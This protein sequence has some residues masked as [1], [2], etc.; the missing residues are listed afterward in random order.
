MIIG[1]EAVVLGPCGVS[2]FAA[3]HKHKE[4]A[5]HKAG[6][7]RTEGLL[8][9]PPTVTLLDKIEAGVNTELLT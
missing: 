8:A 1:G 6:L 5:Q 3:L 7:A 9:R 4:Q 2:D